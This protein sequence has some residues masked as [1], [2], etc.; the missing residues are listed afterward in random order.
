MGGCS[1][2]PFSYGVP[3]NRI[4]PMLALDVACDPGAI[5]RFISN[6]RPHSSSYLWL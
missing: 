6:K 1:P 3:L 4:Q 2:V 5:G